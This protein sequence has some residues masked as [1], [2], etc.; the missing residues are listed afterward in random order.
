M[1]RACT[2]ALNKADEPTVIDQRE[3]E[4]DMRVPCDNRKQLFTHEII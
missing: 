2:N 4:S 1:K 3:I